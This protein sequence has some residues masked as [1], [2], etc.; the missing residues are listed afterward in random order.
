ML[1]ATALIRGAVMALAAVALSPLLASWTI[2]VPDRALSAAHWWGPRRVAPARWLIVA[3]SAGVLAAGGALRS[4]WP[5]WWLYAVAGAVLAVIDLEHCRLPSRL[6][7]PLAVTEL[8]ILAAA[9]LLG[10]DPRRLLGSLIIAAVIGGGWLVWALLTP[11][12]VGLGDVRLAAVG[13][14]LLGWH[15]WQRALDAQLVTFGLALLTASVLAITG[16]R[17][18]GRH[19]AVPMGPALV[20]AAVLLGH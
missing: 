17:R 9:A 8:V 3:S 5:A 12:A 6:L 1:T 11:A 10:H 16:P 4:P 18:R 13:G 14:L 2:T 20:A 7:Y 15:G 19:M